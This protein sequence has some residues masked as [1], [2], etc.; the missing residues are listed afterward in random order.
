MHGG[1]HG[2]REGAQGSER[3]AAAFDGQ[4]AKRLRRKYKEET[5]RGFRVLDSPEMPW[6]DVHV[7]RKYIEL[8]SEAHFS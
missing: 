2:V 7:S 5:S 4:E 3:F 6:Y 1:A 8:E